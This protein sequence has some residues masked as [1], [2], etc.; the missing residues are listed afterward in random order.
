M[1]GWNAEVTIGYSQINVAGSYE[2]IIIGYAVPAE[3]DME[4]E[5]K[6]IEIYEEYAERR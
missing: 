5:G 3:W 1:A 2:W 6:G 4:T